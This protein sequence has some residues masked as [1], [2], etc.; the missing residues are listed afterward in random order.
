MLLHVLDLTTRARKMSRAGVVVDAMSTKCAC[1]P[2]DV[3]FHQLFK[4]VL[5]ASC[6]DPLSFPR[7]VN[8]DLQSP[9]KLFM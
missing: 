5:Q 9:Q 7:V 2:R 6:P 8:K 3:A 1:V 4:I